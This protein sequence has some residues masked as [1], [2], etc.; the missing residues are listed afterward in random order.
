MRAHS[1]RFFHV[2]HK[3]CYAGS[4]FN[5]NL[6]DVLY[7]F[8]SPKTQ[9]PLWDFDRYLFFKTHFF[10]NKGYFFRILL[11][12]TMASVWSLE[13]RSENESFF[14][15]T[16]QDPD[17]VYSLLLLSAVPRDDVLFF[18]LILERA[19]KTHLD[20]SSP[21]LCSSHESSHEKTVVFI[22]HPRHSRGSAALS[23][24]ILIM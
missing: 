13:A 16:I 23:T 7:L 21:F 6:K 4:F 11:R 24:A 5:G 10:D 19:Q 17:A 3:R 8:A 22:R 12:V 20:L 2:S 9:H 18:A 15:R 14:R 1:Y